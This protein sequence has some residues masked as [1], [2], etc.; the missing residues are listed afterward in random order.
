ML[1]WAQGYRVDERSPATGSIWGLQL[2]SRE[3]SHCTV[4]MSVIAVDAGALWKAPQHWSGGWGWGVG[5]DRSTVQA[6]I[7]EALSNLGCFGGMFV[8]CLVSKLCL[9]TDW[10]WW[11]FNV[12]AVRMLHTS[13]DNN[14]WLC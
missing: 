7:G 13:P 8:L 3:H 11:L 14:N 12:Y 2:A 5:G 10:L 6:G 1:F 4:C 9:L